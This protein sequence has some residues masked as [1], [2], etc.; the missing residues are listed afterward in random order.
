MFIQK[1]GNLLH[2][3]HSEEIVTTTVSFP[4]KG[5]PWSPVLPMGNALADERVYLWNTSKLK[6]HGAVSLSWRLVPRIWSTIVLIPHLLL[7]SYLMNAASCLALVSSMCCT[8]SLA[9]IDDV[10]SSLDLLQESK[11]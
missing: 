4:I 9:L 7:P 11:A 2:Y 3:I 5:L 10:K 1:L 6:L 8:E